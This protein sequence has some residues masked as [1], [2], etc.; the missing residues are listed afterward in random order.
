MPKA[1]FQCKGAGKVHRSPHAHTAGCIF[2]TQ[3]EGCKGTG[4]IPDNASRCPKC[5]GEGRYHDSIHEH[6]AGC[7]FCT[8]CATCSR[9]GWI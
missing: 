6:T 3:C 4:A 1:C 2:C 8:P 9:K 5:K 7:I